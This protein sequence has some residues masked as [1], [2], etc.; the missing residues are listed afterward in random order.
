MLNIDVNR[1]NFDV[2]LDELVIYFMILNALGNGQSPNIFLGTHLGGLLN[3]FNVYLFAR[4]TY[5]SSIYAKVFRV[6]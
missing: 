2:V 6:L 1:S 5:I 3:R 4:S